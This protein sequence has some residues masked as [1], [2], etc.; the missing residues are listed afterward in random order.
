MKMKSEKEPLATA[1]E[2]T[3]FKGLLLASKFL[4][5]QEADLAS[6]APIVLL[7]FWIVRYSKI[8][9]GRRCGPITQLLQA[10]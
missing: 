7:I 8:T 1:K 3:A 9:L 10:A 2:K 5:Q 4:F 6:L